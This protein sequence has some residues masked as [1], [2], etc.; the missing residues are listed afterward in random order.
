[1]PLPRTGAC[2]HSGYSPKQWLGMFN[3]KTMTSKDDSPTR[4]LVKALD[5]NDTVKDSVEHAANELLVAN[6]VL[7]TEIPEQP[8]NTDLI[9]ALE[10]SQKVEVRIQ[11]SVEELVEVNALLEREIDERIDLERQLLATEA[12]LAKT[13]N[14]LT[15]QIEASTKRVV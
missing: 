7:Q 6:A 14:A 15:R 12:A 1:M 11:E 8:K 9:H 4:P 10:K 3:L 5:Q 2:L 13:R